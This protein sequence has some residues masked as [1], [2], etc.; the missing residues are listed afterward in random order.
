[1]KLCILPVIMSDEIRR[2]EVKIE[3]T[4]NCHGN[5]CHWVYRIESDM[6]KNKKKTVSSMTGEGAPDA[7]TIIAGMRG[8]HS[9]LDCMWSFSS[10]SRSTRSRQDRRN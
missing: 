1:M 4:L 3:E 9:H 7:R 5:D 8:S 6:T 10:R 2:H